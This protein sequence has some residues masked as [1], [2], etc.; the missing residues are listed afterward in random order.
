[1]FQSK[2]LPYEPPKGYILSHPPDLTTWKWKPHPQMGWLK[3]AG[4][5]G[6][7]RPFV[8]HHLLRQWIFT[9]HERAPILSIKENRKNAVLTLKQLATELDSDHVQLNDLIRQLLSEAGIVS[10][11]FFLKYILGSS[12]PYADLNEDVHLEMANFR[13]LTRFDG[14]R[15][16][17]CI[18]RKFFKSSVEIHGAATWEIVLDPDVTQSIAAMKAERAEEFQDMVVLNFT[19]CDLIKILYP[20]VVPGQGYKRP[21]NARKIICPGRS[22]N[23]VAPTLMSGGAD[24]AWEGVHLDIQNLDDILGLRSVNTR[25]MS[26]SEMERR[27]RW[28]RTAETSLVVDQRVSRINAAFTRYASDDVYGDWFNDTYQMMGPAHW[29]ERYRDR[30]ED[31]SGGKWLTYYS[32][33]AEENGDS[34]FPERVSIEAMDRLKKHDW[35]SYA[36]QYANDPYD[37]D[38]AA[39][40]K[41]KYRRAELYEEEGERWLLV[42]KPIDGEHEGSIHENR[43]RLEIADMDCVMSGDPASTDKAG[44]ARASRSALHVWLTDHDGWH[45]LVY[46]RTGYVEIMTFIDWAF[47]AQELWGDFVRAFFLETN[48]PY[49]MVEPLFQ[50]E[51]RER[52]VYINV[53]PDP[54][55]GDKVAANRTVVGNEAG[56][57]RVAL[58]G[59]IGTEFEEEMRIF[60]GS[61]KMDNIDAARIAFRNSQVPDSPEFLAEQEE[62]EEDYEAISTANL[63]TGY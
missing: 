44:D 13:Q 9:P 26:N 14:A 40:S 15:G 63:T 22:K 52:D 43:V 25:R 11:W 60:P 19:Q 30:H 36:L 57:G 55:T 31:V 51:I 54:S 17:M 2:L 46:C 53:Q 39:F 50:N 29:A 5:D 3:P 28:A 32:G 16:A 56:M 1:M 48:G 37:E 35:W 58:V 49:K 45:Y 62:A 41:I 6:L 27:R 12:G 8:P 21:F 18:S 61:P 10:L 59:S 7:A 42:H 47:E 23:R 24:A 4:V 33:W 34:R 20:Y 38:L